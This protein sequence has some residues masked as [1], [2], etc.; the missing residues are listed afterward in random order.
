MAGPHALQLVQL[1]VA[2]PLHYGHSIIVCLPRCPGAERNKCSAWTPGGKK[3][4]LVGRGPSAAGSSGAELPGACPGSPGSTGCPPADWPPPQSA[5]QGLRAFKGDA[6][7]E[8]PHR[9][10]TRSD[11][12]EPR[13]KAAAPP[14]PGTQGALTVL[15]P[16]HLCRHG[17]QSVRVLSRLVHQT[18][19][20]GNGICPV[21]LKAKRPDRLQEEALPTPGG[22]PAGRQKVLRGWEALL[23]GQPWVPSADIP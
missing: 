2:V 20:Q 1:E 19:V 6:T 21:R 13:A 17:S 18:A 7:A 16:V 23:K 9:R 5:H 11:P 8:T 14:A 3:R 15:G 22:G 12:T 4:P 10:L